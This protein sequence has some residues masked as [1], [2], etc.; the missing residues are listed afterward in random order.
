MAARAVNRDKSG[1]TSAW[2]GTPAEAH[3]FLRGVTAR[4]VVIVPI[5]AEDGRARKPKTPAF[6]PASVVALEA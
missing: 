6:P 2:M 4:Q 1:S 5:M 3:E